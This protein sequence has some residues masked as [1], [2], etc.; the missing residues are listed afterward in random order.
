MKKIII[1]GAGGNS[2][3]IVDIILARIREYGEFLEILGF[4]DDDKSK[5]IMLGYSVL[6]S[7]E[8]ISSYSN[9]AS[10]VFVD[11]IGSNR[12][13]QQIYGKY[14]GVNWYTVVHPSAIIG[15]RVKIGEGSIIMAGVIINADSKVGKKCIINTG[16]I[17]EHDNEIKDFA[18]VASGTVTAGAVSIGKAT[19]LGTG[20]K[21]IQGIKIGDGTM[22]GAGAVVI[23]DIPGNC[24]AVGVPAKIIKKEDKL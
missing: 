7:I 3:V 10:I 22:I 16:A 11:A 4:L 9:D 20:S 13:R 12:V 14:Y 1:I 17:I 19:M 24:T 6:G 18:H 8:S 23:N 15:N 2:K 5:E 21:V